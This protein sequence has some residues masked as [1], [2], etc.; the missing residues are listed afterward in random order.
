MTKEDLAEASRDQKDI[1][2]AAGFDKKFIDQALST[3]NAEL[4]RPT[5]SVR[6]QAKVITAISDGDDFAMS[7]MGTSPTKN[8]FGKFLSKA[9]PLMEPL[10]ARFSSEYDFVVQTYYDS[11]ESGKTEAESL[12]AGRTKLLVVLKKLRPLA[13]DA[14]LSDISAVYADQYNAL[15]SK[16]PVLCYQYASGVGSTV[17][18]SDIPAAL[19]TRENDVNR[20]VVETAT[21]RAIVNATAS[22]AI[23]KKI[24]AGLADKGIKNE[25][26]NL[27][28]TVSIPSE[29][30]NDYC[31]VTTMLFREISKLPQREA[32]IV[33][34]DILT[35]K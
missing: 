13:D 16:S 27:L 1:F 24:G 34:R 6:L 12:A 5:S 20:R 2:A 4:W 3:P 7:G 15:G 26:F 25:Q 28:S 17:T 23:W 22:E 10:K 11:F 32:G 14:V 19:I 31:I 8:D 35:D 9:I 18:S 30:Y 29:K 33:M 21:N